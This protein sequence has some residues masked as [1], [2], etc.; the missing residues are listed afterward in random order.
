MK[1]LPGAAVE[2]S[3]G[4]GAVGV[5]SGEEDAGVDGARGPQ[6]SVR[7]VGAEVLE[8]TRWLRPRSDWDPEAVAAAGPPPRAASDWD[9]VSEWGEPET[10]SDWGG[11]DG[12]AWGPSAQSGW[13]PSAAVS[14]PGRPLY[15][16]GSGGAGDGG[17]PAGVRLGS[18]T[19]SS[20]AT[21]ESLGLRLNRCDK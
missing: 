16:G 5:S 6:P 19:S 21:G 10:V 17:S 8:D 18:Y 9:P 1:V 13:R 3:G 12:S 7:G 14:Q 11:G 20:G 4:G 2:S 15:S